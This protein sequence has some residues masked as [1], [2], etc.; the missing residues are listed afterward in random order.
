MHTSPVTD[1]SAIRHVASSDAFGRAAPLY[2]QDEAANPIV[3]WARRRSLAVL[4][5]AFHAGD[6]V[7]E[8]GCGTGIEAIHLAQ[9]GV[10]VVATDAAEGMIEIVKAKLRPGGPSG[11]MAGNVEPLVLPAHD[12]GRL[13]ER[14]GP[15]SFDGAYSSFGPLNCEPSLEPVAVALA[16]LIKPG[17][18]V[19]MSLLNRY[20][21]WETAWYLRARQPQ[22]AFRR[23]GGA[24]QATSRGPWQNE[25]FTCY[26]WTR[27][28]IEATFRPYFRVVRRRALPWLLPP[29]YLG[30]LV[31][32]APRLF[33]GMARIDWALAGIWPA[34]DIGDHLLLDLIRTESVVDHPQHDKS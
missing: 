20:S 4:D 17:G 19:V 31:P 2:E 34:Y 7:L 27:G 25:K 33:R 30:G 24:A 11:I 29:F 21:L 28:H 5:A 8:I 3:R 22:L 6:R 13:V 1:A 10:N 15:S 26:Y 32:R 9:R 14:Y 16:Q 18:R 23:W 12:L